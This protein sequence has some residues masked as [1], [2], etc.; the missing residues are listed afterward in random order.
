MNAIASNLLLGAARMDP[1]SQGHLKKQVRIGQTVGDAISVV[2]GAMQIGGGLS[3]VFNA[4]KGAALATTAGPVSGG[5]VGGLFVAK[6]MARIAHGSGVVYVSLDNLI[7][8]VNFWRL[9][10]S[11]ESGGGNEPPENG[12]G[13]SNYSNEFDL[14]KEYMDRKEMSPY[15]RELDAGYKTGPAYDGLPKLPSDHILTENQLNALAEN[16][17]MTITKTIPQSKGFQGIQNQI[18]NPRWRFIDQIVGGRTAL[19]NALKGTGATFR[20]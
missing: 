2:L 4:P 5:A 18:D 8:D 7:D 19:M 6:G 14:N 15:I 17:R 11:S 10:S 3:D 9:Y 1:N 12:N 13:D 16:L 20:F